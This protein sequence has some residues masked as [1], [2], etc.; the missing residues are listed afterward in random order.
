MQFLHNSR[1]N[2]ADQELEEEYNEI[3]RQNEVPGVIIDMEEH[4]EPFQL[5]THRKKG[6]KDSNVHNKTYNTRSKV[7]KYN[8]VP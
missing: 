8:L 3:L 4:D 1:A 7:G 5:V 6:K 2:L